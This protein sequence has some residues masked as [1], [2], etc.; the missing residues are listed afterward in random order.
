[1]LAWI[2]SGC[3]AMPDSHVDERDRWIAIDGITIATRLVCTGTLN[4]GR[5][6]PPGF[7]PTGKRVKFPGMDR[8][9]LRDGKIVRA[10]LYRGMLAIGQQIGAAPPRRASDNG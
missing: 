6:E 9:E 5:L 7:D 10:E 3:A 4:E 1:V 2:R 8:I